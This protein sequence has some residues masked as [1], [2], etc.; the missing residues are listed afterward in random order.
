MTR[1][2]TLANLADQNIFS[3]D[4]VNDRVGIGSTTPTTKLDVN[5]TVTATSFSGNGSGLTGIANTATIA[6]DSIVVAGITTINSGGVVITGVITSTT[7][8]G[9]G[10]SLTN[11]NATQLASG[12]VADARFPATLPAL[13]GSALTNLTSSNLTGALPALDG[14]ALTNLN[15]PAGFNELD[16]ALF[17]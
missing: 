7:F 15:I 8:S 14:S 16:A 12:T 2:V 4:G 6:S 3:L 1:A 10:A 11:L 5:G 17:N 9:S 13:N